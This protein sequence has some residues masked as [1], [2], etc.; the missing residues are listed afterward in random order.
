MVIL[1]FGLFLACRG[2][3]IILPEEPAKSLST[4]ASIAGVFV[5]GQVRHVGLCYLNKDGAHISCFGWKILNHWTIREVPCFVFGY[6]LLIFYHLLAKCKFTFVGISSLFSFLYPILSMVP[7]LSCI[8]FND[9]ILFSFT[10]F[11]P[12]YLSRSLFSN[13][14]WL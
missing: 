8:P 9:L 7:I 12:L 2:P 13:H 14:V 3:Y 1:S 5:R 6:S 10:I 11:S 4:P